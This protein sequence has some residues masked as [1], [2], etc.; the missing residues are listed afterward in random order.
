MSD[1]R[2][3]DQAID[4]FNAAERQAFMQQT[5]SRWLGHD[6]PAYII[7]ETRAKALFEDEDGRHWVDAGLYVESLRAPGPTADYLLELLTDD[8]PNIIDMWV[9]TD[10]RGHWNASMTTVTRLGQMLASSQILY[11][12]GPVLLPGANWARTWW[13]YAERSDEQELAWVANGG[14]PTALAFRERDR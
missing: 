5:N 14:T 3:L 13:D 1:K 9:H 10:S 12:P 4:A 2:T 7:G 11:R 6:G 8:E